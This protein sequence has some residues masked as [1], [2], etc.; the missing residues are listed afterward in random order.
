MNYRHLEIFYAV[1]INGTVTAAARQL[2]VSQPSVTTTLKH[3]ETK[4]GFQLF[5]REGGRLLPTDEARLLF[6]EAQ[7]AHDALAALS[8]MA[9][10]IK[11]S[12][13]GHVR[14]AVVP[15]LG[16]DLLPDAIAAFE[17]RHTGFQYSVTT[18]NTEEIIE[19]LDTRKGAYDLGFV[20][21]VEPDA[22]V[23]CMD[24]GEVDVQVVFPSKWNMPDDE[25]IDIAAFA[26]HPYIAGFDRTT[27]GME[28]DRI[29]AEAGIEPRTIARSH[30]HR[31]AG[32]LVERGLG[33]AI[34]DA[35]TTQ[36]ILQG[37]NRDSVDVRRIRGAAAIPVVA[38]YPSQRQLSNAAA[39]F[40][41]CF[42][43]VFNEAKSA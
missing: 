7:R 4:L 6:E 10:G 5:I 20:F 40:I 34:L 42:Q 41:E 29:L 14:V 25:E 37:H 35:L 8:V 11:N 1:M 22:G 15:T 38:V 21:G 2:G 23:S 16:L 24:I 9:D 17:D 19:R 31:L 30:S 12:L 3:A 36:A 32:A 26:E 43:Q 13:G 18:T 33:F 28:G 27:L 39:V